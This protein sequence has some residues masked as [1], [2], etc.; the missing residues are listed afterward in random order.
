MVIAVL[1][2]DDAAW[3]TRGGAPFYSLLVAPFA[4]LYAPY[5][6]ALHTRYYTFGTLMKVPGNPPGYLYYY[7]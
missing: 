2:G 7:A 1:N 4:L 6:K 3:T 5:H